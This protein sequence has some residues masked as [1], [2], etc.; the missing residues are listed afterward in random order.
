MKG[1]KAQDAVFNGF[2]K[3]LEANVVRQLGSN[4]WSLKISRL[5]T[6]ID[7]WKA[8]SYADKR[9]LVSSSRWNN[10]PSTSWTFGTRK[11][12]GAAV[13]HIV[14]NNII[15][16][17]RDREILMRNSVGVFAIYAFDEAEANE[18]TAMAKRLLETPDK[19]VQVRAL[20]FSTYSALKNLL[21]KA[22]KSDSKD[23]ISKVVSRIGI[24]NCY[25]EFIPK[26]LDASGFILPWWS[27]EAISLASRDEVSHLDSF[28]EECSDPMI[29]STLLKKMPIEKV[30]FY[31]DNSSKGS[32]VYSVISRKMEGI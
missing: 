7:F 2:I 14:K 12:Y 6:A 21:P 19:R 3:H 10:Y 13:G 24:I 15:Y 20:E 17:H 26:T 1:G 23:F 18:K 28:L 22:V 5:D 9:R 4:G 16:A 8:I 27:R 31:M 11:P 29:V 25:K 32:I 30:L